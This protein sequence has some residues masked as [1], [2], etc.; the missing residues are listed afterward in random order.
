MSA[1]DVDDRRAGAGERVFDAEFEQ[2]QRSAFLLAR[3]LSRSTDDALDAVQD[4][5]EQAWRYRGTR[6]GPFRPWFLAIVYRAATRRRLPSLPLP[7]AWR[8]EAAPDLVSGHDPDLLAALGRL[9][10]RQR[11]ALWLR[12]CEDMSTAD[13]AGVLRCTESATKQLLLRARA[14]LKEELNGHDV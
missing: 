3:R 8:G 12:Y 1:I 7:A 14:A 4:A 11:A 10:V 13:V 9:P 2:V 5:A 6:H